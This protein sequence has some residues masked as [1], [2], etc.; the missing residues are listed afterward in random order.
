MNKVFIITAALILV[1]IHKSDGYPITNSEQ[2]K[3]II[4]KHNEV[5][6]LS[7]NGQISKYGFGTAAKMYPLTWDNTLA[8]TAELLASS[9]IFNH[10]TFGKGYGQN[11]AIGGGADSNPGIGVP[12]EKPKG[13]GIC[14][15]CFSSDEE[16]IKFLQY[17]WISGRN[18]QQLGP[19]ANT[20]FTQMVDDDTFRIGCALNNQC[21]NQEYY[22]VCNYDPAGNNGNSAYTTGPTGSQCPN[23]KGSDGL[24]LG[25]PSTGSSPSGSPSGSKGGSISQECGQ[26]CGGESWSCECNGNVCNGIR[27]VNC[28]NGRQ[29]TFKYS[30]C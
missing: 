18:E 17:G 2:Q 14:S 9:C 21:E 1:L 6:S 12:D 11:I 16:A 7:A 20:H 8:D 5:R 24:C 15:N 3:I 4:N 22:L 30:P 25:T 19:D 28:C 10:N 29:L 26:N 23:G 27:T 13:S